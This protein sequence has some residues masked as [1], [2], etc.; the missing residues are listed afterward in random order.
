[1]TP[2]RTTT[3]VVQ[4]EQPADEQLAM[5]AYNVKDAIAASGLVPASSVSVQ[6]LAQEPRVQLNTRKVR[7]VESC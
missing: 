5:D 4:V 6:Q 3:F 2:P 1:M 7:I